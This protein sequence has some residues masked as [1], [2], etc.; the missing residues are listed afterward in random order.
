MQ[1]DNPT[2]L[3]VDYLDQI[4]PPEKPN[5]GFSKKQILIFAG[6]GVAL[7]LAVLLMMLNSALQNNR[8]EEMLAARLITIQKV[9]DESTGNLKNSKLRALNSDLKLYIVDVMREAEAPFAASKVTFSEINPNVTKRENADGLLERL[10]DERL[11][12]RYDRSYA[13][14]MASLIET[15]LIQMKAVYGKTSN[16]SLKDFLQKTYDN[17]LPVQEQFENI[18]L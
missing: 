8:P 5:K 11:N 3:S 4:A 2:Q 10:E 7:I 9:V 1:P 17:L 16:K 18:K 13:R 12:A 15:T 6:L 14:E